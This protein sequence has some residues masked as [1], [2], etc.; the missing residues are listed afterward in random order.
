MTFTREDFNR[1]RELTNEH[2]FDYAL[3]TDGFSEVHEDTISSI[4]VYEEIIDGADRDYLWTVVMKYYWWDGEPV[5]SVT[6]LDFKKDEDGEMYLV[7]EGAVELEYE[8]AEDGHEVS[9]LWGINLE[10]VIG[11]ERVPA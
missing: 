11:Y 7:R 4:Q 10:E 9:Y 3:C 6:Y 2:H 1:V 8:E 5:F